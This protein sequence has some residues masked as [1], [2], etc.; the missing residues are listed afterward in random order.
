MNERLGKAVVTRTVKR[1][2]RLKD[3]FCGCKKGRENVLVL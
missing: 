2:K 1:H 3:A